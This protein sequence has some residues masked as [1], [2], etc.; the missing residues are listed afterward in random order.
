[1][2]AG[3]R[4]LAALLLLM[5][6]A[7][8]ALA[9]PRADAAPAPVVLPLV[10]HVVQR[11]GASIAP[12]GFIAQRVARANVIF[13]PYGVAFEVV[14][15]VPLPAAHAVL[16]ERSDRDALAA[17]VGRE[18]IDWFV[19]EVL[20]DVDEPGRLRRGVHWHARTRAGAHFVVL[21]LL[22]G[23]D[24]LAHELGHY[25]GNPSHSET[26]GNLMSYQHTE[27]TPFLD[28]AQQ[29]KLR[30]ALRGYLR[31]GELAPRSR[32]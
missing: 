18:V 26:P 20:Y 28:E 12:P 6:A 8:P 22:A 4:R 16:T 23:E 11:D 19:V 10:V 2:S 32:Q 29:A 30:R 13:A 17:Y 25:L 3:P 24:V 5:A 9:Q 1:L 31:R 7:Q 15:E 14:K 27:V 21:S